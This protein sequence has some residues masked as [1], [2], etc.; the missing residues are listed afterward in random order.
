MLVPVIDLSGNVA[1]ELW[2]RYLA[3]LLAAFAPRPN[4]PSRSR[5]LRHHASGST[6]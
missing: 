6:R 2:R 4:R 1:P 3:L 5:S